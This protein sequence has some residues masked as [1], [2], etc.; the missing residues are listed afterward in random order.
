MWCVLI[1]KWQGLFHSKLQTVGSSRGCMNI[2]PVQNVLPGGSKISH[3][4]FITGAIQGSVLHV[5]KGLLI[6]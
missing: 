6:H 1:N 4:D 3:L 2:P 5:L